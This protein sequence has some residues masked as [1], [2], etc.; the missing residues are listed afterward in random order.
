[1]DTQ[2]QARR[3]GAVLL[4]ATYAGC[5]LTNTFFGFEM[6]TALYA[7]LVAVLF[8]FCRDTPAEHKR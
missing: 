1:L 7:C 2:R 8:G 3:V 4:V 5:G 6:H